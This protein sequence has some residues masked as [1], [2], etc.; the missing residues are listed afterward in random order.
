MLKII[1]IILIFL[2]S[3]NFWFLFSYYTGFNVVN[4]SFFISTVVAIV[5]IIL[6]IVSFV[7]DESKT[8]SIYLI[9]IAC[10]LFVSLHYN[11]IGN[12]HQG[13]YYQEGYLTFSKYKKYE[14]PNV[15]GLVDKYGQEFLAPRYGV[16]LK[17]FDEKRKEEVFVGIR[18]FR[19][20]DN[21]A[22]S[23][24]KAR[25][26]DT[27]KYHVYCQISSFCVTIFSLDGKMVDYNTINKMCC[28]DMKEYVCKHIGDILVDY[29]KRLLMYDENDFFCIRQISNSHRNEDAEDKTSKNMNSAEKTSQG[30]NVER[31]QPSSNINQVQ[32]ALP[33]YETRDVWVDC[34]NCIGTGQCSTCHG[35]GWCIS[36]WSDGSYNDTYQCVVCHGSGRCQM[37]YGTKGHYERQVFRVR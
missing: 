37:C 4:S 15:R 31:N 35:E 23:I 36:T 24:I 27:E 11:N 12:F 8:T 3:K 2:F 5:G 17:V 28:K 29:G 18:I 20:K 7:K 21:N 19:Y 22:D 16:I 32:Q 33:E 13:D 1:S 25:S 14:R 34:I 9:V 6:L 10:V 26:A 30:E